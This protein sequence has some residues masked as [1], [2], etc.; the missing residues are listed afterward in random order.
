MLKKSA[1]VGSEAGDGSHAL[2]SLIWL[3]AS[4]IIEKDSYT[5]DNLLHNLKKNYNNSKK[6]VLVVNL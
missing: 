6:H 3:G 5:N 2:S 1:D 4:I